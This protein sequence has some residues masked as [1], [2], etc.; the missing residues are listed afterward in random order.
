[1]TINPIILPSIILIGSA[2]L[3]YPVLLRALPTWTRIAFAL[4]AISGVADGILGFRLLQVPVRS[5]RGVFLE[6]YQTLCGG[7]AMGLLV[8]L[9]LSGQFTSLIA[10]SKQRRAKLQQNI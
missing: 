10:A 5:D 3:T 6:H 7:F 2:L 4:V 9:F 1:M 8:C